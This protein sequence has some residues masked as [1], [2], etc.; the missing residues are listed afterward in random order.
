MSYIGTVDLWKVIRRTVGFRVLRCAFVKNN[1]FPIQCGRS[2][3]VGSQSGS[4]PERVRWFPNSFD[5]D[6]G[7][8]AD[9]QGNNISLIWNDG[10]EVVGDDLQLMAI[11][12]ETLQGSST[13]VDQSK[14]IG[15][16]RVKLEMSQ[17]SVGST[18]CA[19]GDLRAIVVI[20]SVD[21]VVIGR[22]HVF[23]E[24]VGDRNH[25][26][27]NRKIIFVVIITEHNRSEVDIIFSMLWAVN[28]HGAE[29]SIHSLSRVMPVVP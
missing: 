26:L 19:V 14:T 7:A 25:F 9:P 15:F 28:D 22:R 29:E 5:Q 3:T 12:A 18:L 6:V 1:T 23:L 16:A 21:Q 4:H 20:L 10:R 13:R 11:N 17:G 24:I 8:L 27:D 2:A